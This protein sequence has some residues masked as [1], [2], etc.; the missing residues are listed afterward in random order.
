MCYTYLVES[1]DF[2]DAI[3]GYGFLQ[4]Y[5]SIYDNANKRIGLATRTTIF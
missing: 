5:V 1:P 4:Q 2:V 3:L